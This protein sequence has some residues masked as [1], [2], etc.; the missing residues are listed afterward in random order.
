MPLLRHECDPHSHRHCGRP[1]GAARTT[2][3]SDDTARNLFSMV[4][5][6]R[7][8]RVPVSCYNVGNA[9][10]DVLGDPQR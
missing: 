3:S 9:R 2:S 8:S 5:E 7:V 1:P 6:R 10:R 4:S